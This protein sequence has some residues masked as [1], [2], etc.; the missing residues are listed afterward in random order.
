MSKAWL[1]GTHPCNGYLTDCT[2]C[3]LAIVS[4]SYGTAAPAS[5]AAPASFRSSC[6]IASVQRL[7]VYFGS[8]SLLAR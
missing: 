8:T 6:R 7:A 4:G 2:T 1:T 5:G 3:T